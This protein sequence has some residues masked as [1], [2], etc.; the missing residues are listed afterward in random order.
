MLA[1]RSAWGKPRL[2]ALELLR[3]VC[4]QGLLRAGRSDDQFYVQEVDAL[5]RIRGAFEATCARSVGIGTGYGYEPAFD[6]SMR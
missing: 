4:V 6:L 5:K 3:R 1:L 2:T